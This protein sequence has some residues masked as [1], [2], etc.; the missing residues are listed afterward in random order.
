MTDAPLQRRRGE[1]VVVLLAIGVLW[2]GGR[3]LTWETPI[4]PEG[5]PGGEAARLLQT[6]S[7]ACRL[8]QWPRWLISPVSSG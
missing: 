7:R 8:R 6:L 2:I 1:P 5:M 3:A 4:Y